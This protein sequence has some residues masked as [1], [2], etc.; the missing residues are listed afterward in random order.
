MEGTAWSITT[1]LENVSSIFSTAGDLIMANPV[2]SAFVGL[3]LAA[4]GIG[5]FREVIHVR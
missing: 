5:L 2:S 1:L 3:A 4:G